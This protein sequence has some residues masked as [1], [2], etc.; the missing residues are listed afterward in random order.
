MSENSG[1]GKTKQK[2]LGG[3]DTSISYRDMV[4]Y[5][6]VLERKSDISFK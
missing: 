1:N 5:V 6:G 2:I 3:A 4:Q